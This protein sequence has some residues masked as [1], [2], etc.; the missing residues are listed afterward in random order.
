MGSYYSTSLAAD[1]LHRCYAIAPP[2][3]QQYLREEVR[4]VLERLKPSDAVVELGCG[5][6]RVTAQLAEVAR[7]VVGIDSARASLR[8]ATALGQPRC[9]YVAMDA[10]RLAFAD[11]SL[12]VVV[13][14]QNGICSFHIEPIVLL[15]EA[16][17]VVRRP[18]R[19]LFSTY[20]ERFW[21]DRLEWFRLQAAEGLVGP[22]DEQATRPGTIVCRDGFCVGTFSPGGF[23]AAC[24]ALGVA[25]TLTEVD[26]SSLFCEIVV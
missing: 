24:A 20:S 18:G 10:S 7:L 1:R 23:Q 22:I 11:R 13:C 3:V 21:P 6:G 9:R 5:Y 2:R 12:D 19:V 8:L 14:V 25:C 4:F 15:S 17:R 26:G 16:L